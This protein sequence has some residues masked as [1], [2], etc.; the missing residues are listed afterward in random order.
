M[1]EEY[2]RLQDAARDVECE[3]TD[4]E[5]NQEVSSAGELA[6][7]E[8]RLDLRLVKRSPLVKGRILLRSVNSPAFQQR[9]K[10]PI[11]RLPHKYHSQGLRQ[12]VICLPGDVFVTLNITYYHRRKD[13]AKALQKTERGLYPAFLLLSI[14]SGRTPHVCQRMAKASALL[15]SH[16]EAAEMLDD[17]GI[18][19]SVN[20]LREVCGHI[21]R[22]LVQLTFSGSMQVEGSVEK[23]RIVVSMDDGRV[24]GKDR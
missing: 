11:R 12:K 22:K 15:G 21:G 20:K 16:E 23:R 10:E 13:S 18:S 5:Q 2:L 19:V 14:S 4:L 1:G 17:D 8:R 3:I 7:V 24:P 9:Q 6:T